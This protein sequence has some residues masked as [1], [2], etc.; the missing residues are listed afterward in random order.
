M[1]NV[2]CAVTLPLCFISPGMLAGWRTRASPFALS[3]EHL[4]VHIPASRFQARLPHRSWH[5]PA[6]RG[7][8]RKRGSR[9][10]D[11]PTMDEVATTALYGLLLPSGAIPMNSNSENAHAKMRK[12]SRQAGHYQRM[13]RSDRGAR[14]LH[15]IIRLVR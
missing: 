10:T 6:G 1:D 3:P 5:R 13:D 14:K 15:G 8:G 9:E 4:T 12:S 7:S 2:R 11:R